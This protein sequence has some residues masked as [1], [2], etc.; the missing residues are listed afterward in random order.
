MVLSPANKPGQTTVEQQ[1]AEG[2]NERLQADPRDQK[3]VER[4]D[5][6]PAGQD[7]QHS[8]RP[9]PVPE[10]QH[11]RKENAKQGKQRSDREVNAAG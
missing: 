3:S 10:R 1:A 4:A 11:H 5:D 9:G 7:R 6:S 2:D 8:E